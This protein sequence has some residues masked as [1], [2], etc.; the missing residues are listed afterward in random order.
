MA[1]I[2]RNVLVLVFLVLLAGCSTT[3]KTN[4]KTVKDGSWVGYTETGI[5]S[6]YADKHQNRKTA[7]GETYRHD[8]K[9]A[10][11]KELP[12]GSVVEVT[13]LAN[14][15]SVVVAINDRGP[16]VRGRIIDLSKS[17][18]SSIGSLS[19]GLLDVRIEVVK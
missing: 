5:A 7:N 9:T 12:F 8:L 15:K 4:T 19:S 11:H 3:P 6:Y 18:F 13:N 16:F 1:A 17:A 2:S 14:G 10:A